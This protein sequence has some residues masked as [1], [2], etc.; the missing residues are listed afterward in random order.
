TGQ[1]GL[2]ALRFAI[3]VGLEPKSGPPL[4]TTL[5]WQ[6]RDVLI[7]WAVETGDLRVLEPAVIH[8]QIA[9]SHTAFA[10]VAPQLLELARK[11]KKAQLL[12]TLATGGAVVDPTPADL[13]LLLRYAAE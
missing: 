8:E 7:P 1:H 10:T 2:T 13:E 6:H 12:A 9:P 5:V 4:P 3:E 11:Q